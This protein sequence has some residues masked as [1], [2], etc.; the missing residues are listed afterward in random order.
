MGKE[1]LHAYQNK[2]DTAKEFW[3]EATGDGLSESTT[4]MIAKDAE[5]KRY[6][7]N[8]YQGHGELG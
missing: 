5:E 6:D 4:P 8:D 1:N 3:L 7:T 2:N